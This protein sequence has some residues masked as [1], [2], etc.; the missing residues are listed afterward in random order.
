MPGLPAW[1]EA[2]GAAGGQR[3]P[4]GVAWGGGAAVSPAHPAP[5]G[6]VRAAVSR[7]RPLGSG[8]REA[9]AR[10]WG[11]PSSFPVGLVPFSRAHGPVG[12]GLSGGGA[13][14]PSGSTREL[15]PLPSPRPLRSRPA[16]AAPGMPRPRGVPW[17]CNAQCM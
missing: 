16:A 1:G 6:W 11:V 14:G 10:Y 13:A 15:Q 7:V 12:T 4:A 5:G 3:D 9:K 8:R 17:L 2:E